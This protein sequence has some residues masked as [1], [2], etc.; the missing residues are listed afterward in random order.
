[1]NASKPSRRLNVDPVLAAF[2]NARPLDEPL[3][4]EDIV[5]IEAAMAQPG[6]ALTTDELLEQLRPKT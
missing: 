3:D 6:L 4:L 1:V 5:A 2:D